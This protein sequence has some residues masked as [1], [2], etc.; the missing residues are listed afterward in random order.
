METKNGFAAAID[1]L[2][3]KHWIII[4]ALLALGAF[5]CMF[6]G[7]LLS[8]ASGEQV[9]TDCPVCPPEIECPTSE[10]VAGCP[11]CEPETVTEQV[12]VTRIVEVEKPVEVTRVVK[13]TTQP[14]T[15][16]V[17]VTATPLIPVVEFMGPGIFLVGVDI[18]PG[19]YRFE[20]LDEHYYWERLSCLDGTFSC[21]I[22][23][24]GGEGPGYVTIYPTDKAFNTTWRTHFVRIE[25]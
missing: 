7:F 10:P 11:P 14:E 8:S 20:L 16:E 24:D 15:K 22:T 23:N 12:E 1:A 5:G 4:A 6:S 9:V 13:I 18:E 25:Q 2:R 21:I 3:I 17:V 19:T